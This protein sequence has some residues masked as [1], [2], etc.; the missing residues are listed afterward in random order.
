MKTLK[1]ILLFVLV[2]FVV[3][4]NAQFLKNT[5]TLATKDTLTVG[6]SNDTSIVFANNSDN[7]PYS[8][9]KIFGVWKQGT[10]TGCYFL[11]L[12]Y[13]PKPD[14]V[15]SIYVAADSSVITQ[16]YTI[17]GWK[18]VPIIPGD[19]TLNQSKQ[20]LPVKSGTFITSFKGENSK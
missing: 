20:P 6:S 8:Y 3:S 7:S 12:Q 2:L 19:S 15:R 17:F 13:L 9:D 10:V 5:T 18:N 4:A 14:Y 11:N 16:T 1:A